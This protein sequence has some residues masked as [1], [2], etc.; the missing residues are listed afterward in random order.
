MERSL[1]TVKTQAEDFY[2]FLT[3]LGSN[4]KGTSSQKN[5]NNPKWS[6]LLTC[7]CYTFSF[8]ANTMA[9]E[10]RNRALCKLT[11]TQQCRL[12]K[13]QSLTNCTTDSP[14]YLTVLKHWLKD[15]SHWSYN[16]ASLQ[17]HLSLEFQCVPS[18][19]FSFALTPGT[20]PLQLHGSSKGKGLHFFRVDLNLSKIKQANKLGPEVCTLWHCSMM[21]CSMTKGRAKAGV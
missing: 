14:H 7:F 16:L 18:G 1:F 2:E 19:T 8:I 12:E 6:D 13:K 5:T 17:N 21:L 9:Q 10:D 15:H 4:A 20:Q 3:V 11:R